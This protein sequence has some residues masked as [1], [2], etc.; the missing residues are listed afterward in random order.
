MEHLHLEEEDDEIE[1]PEEELVRGRGGF[2][3][4][5]CLIGRFLSNKQVRIH[6]MK[7]HMKRIWSLVKGVE[8]REIKEGVFIFQFFHQRDVQKVLRGGPWFFNKHMMILGAMAEGENPEQ[9]MLNT[10]PFWIQVHNL[11]SGLYGGNGGTKCR[12]LCG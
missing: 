7:E 8:I 9:V 1:I 5:L 10:V 4:A 12:K 2:D 11:P 3:P 6:M